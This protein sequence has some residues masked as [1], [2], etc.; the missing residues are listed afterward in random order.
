MLEFMVPDNYFSKEG[1]SNAKAARS[2]TTWAPE[3]ERII[4]CATHLVLFMIIISSQQRLMVNDKG[5]NMCQWLSY[6]K[7][8]VHQPYRMWFNYPEPF[9][10]DH[11]KLK[12]ADGGR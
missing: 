10:S 4:I 11:Y 2:L 3:K 5:L 6:P 7:S 12:M 9:E 1:E 8:L